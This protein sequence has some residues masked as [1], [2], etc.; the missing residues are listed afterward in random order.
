MRLAWP[1]LFFGL[2]FAPACDLFAPEHPTITVVKGDTLS[3]LARAHGVTVA[4]LKEWNGLRSD[5]IEI[6]QILVLKLESPAEATA[7]PPSPTKTPKRR[8][9]GLTVRAPDTPQAAAPAA[10]TMPPANPGLAGPTDVEGD[11]GMVA[12]AG[13]GLDE[14]RSSMNTFIQHTARCLP[15]GGVNGVLTLDFVVGCDGRV[16]DLT[17][18]D[19]G[20]LSGELGGCV[21]ETL[22]HTP[23]PAH[24]LPDG[25]PFTFPLRFSTE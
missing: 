14:V 13:L 23:F 6:G 21:V 16:S 20:G 17:V 12:S 7:A 11:E 10:F 2:T 9:K 22:R 1:L 18:T 3:K 19:D 8:A 25:F 15:E 4:Q 5:T 24:D